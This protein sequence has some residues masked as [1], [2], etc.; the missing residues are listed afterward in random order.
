VKKRGKNGSDQWNLFRLIEL[1][2][3]ST[4]GSKGCASGLIGMVSRLGG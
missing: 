3:A 1:K 2:Q 4:A